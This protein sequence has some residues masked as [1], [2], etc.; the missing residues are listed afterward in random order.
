VGRAPLTGSPAA[1]AP[2]AE[3]P[4]PGWQDAVPL[5]GALRGYQGPWL[6]RDLL[7]ALTVWALLIPQGLAYSQLAGL[8]P[9]YGLYASIGAL[10]GYAPMGR[11]RE[12]SAGPEATVALLSAGT[13]AALAGSDPARYIALAGGLALVVGIMLALAGLAG[14]GFVT[15]YLSRPLLLGY[16]TGSAVVMIV[17]QLD[18]LLGIK[19]VAQDD[20]MA[21]LVETVRRLP[22]TDPTTLAVGLL[23][24]A[25]I[26]VVRRVNRRLP[27]YLLAVLAAIAVSAV[28]DLAGRGVNVVGEIPAGL[29]PLGL[30]ALQA[31]DLSNLALPAVAIAFL[32]FADSGV[33][34]QVLMRRGG[35]RVD[36]NREFFGLAAANA[37]A[38]LT[39]GFPVNGSQSRSFTAADTGVRSQVASLVVAALVVVTLLFLT[40]LFAP[41]PKAALAG[42]IIVVAAGLIEPAAYRQLARVDRTEAG[43]ALTAALIVVMVGMLAGVIVVI[44]LS[45]L[46]VAQ[47]AAVP[48]TAVLVQGPAGRFRRAGGGSPREAAEGLVIYR[49]DAP[50]FFAN[51]TQFADEIRDLAANGD[52]PV[53]RIIVSAEA[54]TDMDSTAAEVL[55]ELLGE[56]RAAGVELVVAR[57]KAPLRAALERAGLLAEIGADHLYPTVRD[58]VN[59]YAGGR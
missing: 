53:R 6:R 1:E 8:D 20:T 21:E 7:A 48:R 27:A 5:L 59:A 23:V 4:A 55:H 30:P 3:S 13:V 51:A 56:L 41:L 38:A 12:L 42:V 2:P 58:A 32:V 22:E 17:S 54:V 36:A 47:R 10:L 57:A 26:L 9:V 49:F 35:Y 31:G 39:G 16:V 33:T 50:L 18:S 28:L 52:P 34:G 19:L 25:V 45:L 37:G 11:V 29:P 14:L 46:L 24:I 44:V 15:R 43:L 40:P